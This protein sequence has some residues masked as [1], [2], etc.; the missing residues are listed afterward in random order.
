M[1][2]SGS[3]DLAESALARATQVFVKRQP[4]IHLFAARFKE[5][6]GDIGGARASYQLVHAEISTGLLEAI[7]KH[8]KMEHCLVKQ[9]L[10]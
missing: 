8:A 6:G 9:Y 7:I 3:M 2:A 1:E 5:Q 10:G 4:E